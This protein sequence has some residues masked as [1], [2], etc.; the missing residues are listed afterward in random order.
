[1][2]SPLIAAAGSSE[3]IAIDTLRRHAPPD[4]SN[5]HNVYILSEITRT[6]LGYYCRVF[7]PAFINGSAAIYELT[8]AIQKATGQP[9]KE[10]GGEVWLAFKGTFN[11]IEAAVLMAKA[12]GVK[13]ELCHNVYRCN[14]L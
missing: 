1:M 7:V 14:P 10:R 3:R 13:P 2:N 6:G 5:P 11:P 4:V 12:Q 9:Y 8:G